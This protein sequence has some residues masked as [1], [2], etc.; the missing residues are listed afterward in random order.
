MAWRG[1]ES[2]GTTAEEPVRIEPLAD[3]DEVAPVLNEPTPDVAPSV[4][5]EEPPPVVSEPG[6][7]REPV[8][9]EPERPA[10]ARPT[11]D[12]SPT[13]TPISGSSSSESAR[14]SVASAVP[15]PSGAT[16][17]AEKVAD[18]PPAAEAPS[19]VPEP[20]DVAAPEPEPE[21]QAAS[22]TATVTVRGD[23]RSV[24]LQSASGNFRAGEV[25]PGTYRIKVFFEGMDPKNVG[26]I[27]LVAGQQATLVCQRA[28]AVCKEE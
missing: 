5:V 24:W 12:A 11:P 7:A 2:P 10:T 25:P 3:G 21:P 27:S 28:L 17:A 23:A 22:T 1:L 9:S 4:P 19:A 8:R 16:A 13:P 20:I 15:A 18:A 26:E 6:P 14:G